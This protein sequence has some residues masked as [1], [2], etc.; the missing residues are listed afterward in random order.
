MKE[1]Y[2]TSA[3]RLRIAPE[4]GDKR[5]QTI[6]NC[7]WLLDS[8]NNNHRLARKTRMVPESQLNISSDEVNCLV[9]SYLNDSGRNNPVFTE[10][11]L[12]LLVCDQD[13]STRR[14]VFAKKPVLMS[15]PTQKCTY[16][17]VAWSRCCKKPCCISRSRRIGA[18]SVKIGLSF[19]A[20]LT[21]PPQ[22]CCPNRI[23]KH[24]HAPPPLAYYHPMSA[25]RRP[26]PPLRQAERPA[27]KKQTA[28]LRTNDG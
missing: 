4:L 24:L 1:L 2:I 5:Q 28:R 11:E 25:P 20:V 17:G 26:W 23:L 7:H 8:Y 9:N 27:A 10:T 22:P 21:L 18:G 6:A 16:R 3:Y 19:Y 13:S 15:R 12:S 14:L